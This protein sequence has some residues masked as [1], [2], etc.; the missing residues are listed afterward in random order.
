MSQL[1]LRAASL[2]RAGEPWIACIHTHNEL[3]KRFAAESVYNLAGWPSFSRGHLDFV[4][5]SVV[6]CYAVALCEGW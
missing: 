2:D 6:A 3:L 1:S 4:S 5:P